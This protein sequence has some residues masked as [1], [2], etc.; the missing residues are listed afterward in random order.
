MEIKKLAMQHK[1]GYDSLTKYEK[2]KHEWAWK[3]NLSV[4]LFI[5]YDIM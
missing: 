3:K 2:G 4:Y 1:T 5:S